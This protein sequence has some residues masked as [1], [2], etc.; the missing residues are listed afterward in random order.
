MVGGVS[1]AAGVGVVGAQISLVALVGLF[2]DQPGLVEVVLVGACVVDSCAVDTGV[3]PSLPP[4]LSGAGGVACAPVCEVAHVL[5]VS[6]QVG[7]LGGVAGGDL[8]GRGS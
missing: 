7:V 8:P 6:A 4:G 2:I 5:E 3:R 1:H